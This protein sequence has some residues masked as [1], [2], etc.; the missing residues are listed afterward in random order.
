VQFHYPE[1][2]CTYNT[3]VDNDYY[4][5]DFDPVGGGGGKRP[6]SAILGGANVRRGYCPP[7]V[8]GSNVL[9]S[10]KQTCYVVGSSA[11]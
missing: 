4:S 6:P 8:Q 7:I 9:H 5:A 11:S 1:V 10:C 3:N 2:K